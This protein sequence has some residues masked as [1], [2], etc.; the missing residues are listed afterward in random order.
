[1]KLIEKYLTVDY[2]GINLI[3]LYQLD[4]DGGC[5]FVNEEF[6][7]DTVK[8]KYTVNVPILNWENKKDLADKLFIDMILKCAT[9]YNYFSD[10]LDHYEEKD[11]DPKN[12]IS[13]PFNSKIKTFELLND[14]NFNINLIDNFPKDII[15]FLPDKD[16]V[17]IITIRE[18]DDFGLL[19]Y[20]SFAICSLK[21]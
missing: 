19:I 17:G 13:S 14:Y 1:M 15:I 21:I 16:Y 3:P 12:I 7:I 2:L 10:I 11:L 6:E 4:Y 18:K 9:Q 8:N 20:N 5:Y